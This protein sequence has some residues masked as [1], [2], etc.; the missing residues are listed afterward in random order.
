MSAL[1]Q[2]TR[3]KWSDRLHY[4]GLAERGKFWTCWCAGRLAADPARRLGHWANAYRAALGIDSGGA[5]R[6]EDKLRPGILDRKSEDQGNIWF[7]EKIGWDRYRVRHRDDNVVLNRSL[8][9]KAPGA[10]GERGVFVIWFE[11]NLIAL[12]H[13]RQLRELLKDYRIVFASS[14]SPPYP[15][16]IWPLAGFEDADVT[17]MLSNARDEEWFRRM[18]LGFAVTPLYMSSWVDPECY[19]PKPAEERDIDVLMVANWAPFKRHWLLFEA[20]RALPANW[21]VVLAG[22]PEA[23]RTMGHVRKMAAAHRAP[24]QIEFHDRLRVDEVAALQERSKTSL[25]LSRREGSCVVVAESLCAGAAVGLLE[26]AHIGSSAFVNR[27]TGA[28]L[29]ERHLAEDLGRLVD[30]ASAGEF[31]PLEWARGSIGCL[32]S[33]KLLNEGLRRRAEERGEPWTKD[34]APMR[35]WGVPGYVDDAEAEQ[36]S[37]SYRELEARHGIWVQGPVRTEEARRQ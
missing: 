35:V 6:L 4:G 11:S 17:L 24:Q 33:T 8:I 32:Q 37:G 12:L 31:S 26:G 20:L 16:A 1:V 22:Q 25:I 13:C 27:R 30:A 14:W 34:I 5:R 18:D 7:R 15:Q 23:G 9:L 3:W 10:G 29:R 36:I 2:R 19:S 28:F 21:R